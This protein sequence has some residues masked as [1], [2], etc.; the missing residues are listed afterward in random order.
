SHV[1]KQRQN[2]ERVEVLY[3]DGLIRCVAPIPGP[4]STAPVRECSV[5]ADCS[6]R[7][8]YCRG[9]LPG[10]RGFRRDVMRYS[11]RENQ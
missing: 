10:L 4:C 1:N 8:T 11:C 9:S 5:R 2:C 3:P 6:N 7:I